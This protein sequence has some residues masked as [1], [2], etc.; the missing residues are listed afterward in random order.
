MSPE[1]GQKEKNISNIYS[2]AEKAFRNGASIVVAPEIIPL[3]LF[4]L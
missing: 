2:L 1:Y 4:H 3:L